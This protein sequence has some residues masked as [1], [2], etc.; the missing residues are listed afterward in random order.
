MADPHHDS[1]GVIAL[2]PLIFLVAIVLG[3]LI[4][5]IWPFPIPVPVLGRWVAGAVIVACVVLAT[6]ARTTFTRAGTNVNPH[7]PSTALVET[8]PFRFTRNPMYMAMTIALVALAFATRVGWFLVLT[9]PVFALIHRGVV[10]RE[11]RYLAHKFGVPYD[12]YR[13]RV[14][15]YL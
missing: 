12:E 2:P 14:R 1:P 11:E 10:L 8:G 6:W 4:H 3:T 13:Q 7:L 15:R 5:F 9:V